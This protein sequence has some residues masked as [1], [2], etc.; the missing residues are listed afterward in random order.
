MS[1]IQL[2]R[3]AMGA[4]SALNRRAQNRVFIIAL[5]IGDTLALAAAFLLVYEVRF[6][7][8]LAIF[9]ESSMPLFVSRWGL[10]LLIPICLF[11]LALFQLYDTQYLLGGMQEYARV[12]N[13]TSV[14]VTATIVISFLIPVMRISRGFLALCW[15]FLT[16]AL[17][18]ERFVLR[19]I[20]YRLRRRGFLTRRTLI[21]GSDEDARHIAEQL[22]ATPTCGAELLGFVAND[23]PPGAVM[24]SNLPVLGTLDRLPALVERLGVEELVVSSAGLHRTEIIQIFQNYAYADV[25]LRFLPGLFEIF[26]TGVRVKEI[27]SVPL[28]SMNRVR[29]DPWTSALKTVVDY[30]GALTLLVLLSPLLVTLALLIKLD[31]PGPV[32]H[33]RRVVG[34]GGQTFDAFK[35]RT[36]YVNGDEILD[37]YPE[38]KAKLRQNHKL[39]YDPR[40]TRVGAVLRRLSLDELPQFLNVL[41]GQMSLVGPRMITLEEMDKYG[42]WRWNLLTVKPGI[43]GLW[44]ISGRSDLSYDERVR[45]DMYYIRNYTLWLDLQ[46]LWRTLPA[47][48][49]RQGAY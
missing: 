40:I 42:K 6:D 44:Q 25:D 14:L 35:F 38:L 20:V 12:F 15:I 2:D 37:R 43:T 33:R 3:L 39:R 18:I 5:L 30:L 1:T 27:G 49:R 48:L 28:V 4:Q 17:L 47:V 19:R 22:L 9:E 34:R 16:A 45:L 10:L 8:N 41:L 13:A 32:L 29:L 26:A 31:S 11:A 46:I 7:F 36:M 21:V 23:V 24:T